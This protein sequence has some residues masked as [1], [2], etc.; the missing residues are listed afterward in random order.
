MDPNFIGPIA[1]DGAPPAPSTST[2]FTDIGSLVSAAT[3]VFKNVVNAVNSSK[4]STAQTNAQVIAIANPP[5][6]QM[7]AIFALIVIALIAWLR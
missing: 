1:P 5:N 4:L 7:W 2:I 3:G 6:W